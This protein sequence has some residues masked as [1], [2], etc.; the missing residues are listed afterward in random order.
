M[1]W[2]GKQRLMRNSVLSNDNLG[3]LIHDRVLEVGDEQSMVFNNAGL[4]PVLSPNAPQYDVAKP[5]QSTTKLTKA[6]LK[7]C[8]KV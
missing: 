1:R 3:T 6:E 4:P 2:G 8:Q 7:K 5:G